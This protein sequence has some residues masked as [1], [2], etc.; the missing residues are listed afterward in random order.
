M[1]HQNIMSAMTKPVPT[2]T[3]VATRPGIMKEWFST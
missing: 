3:T 1:F 2:E